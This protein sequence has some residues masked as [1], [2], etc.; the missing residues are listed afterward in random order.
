MIAKMYE[1]VTATQQQSQANAKVIANME[2]QIGQMAENQQKRDDGKLPSTTEV[3][4]THG[5]RAG[6]EHV[7]TVESGWRKFTL[8]D[9]FEVGEMEPEERE[10]VLGKLETEESKDKESPVE[11]GTQLEKK[12]REEEQSAVAGIKQKK[13]DKKGKRKQEA[14]K[15]MGPLINQPRWDELKDAPEDTRILQEMCE[16]NGQS[17]APTPNTVRLTVKASEALL[18]TLPKKEKDPGSPLITTTI[19]DVVIRNTLLDLGASVNI[20]PGY[21]YDKYKNEEIE[22]AKVVLQLADQSTKVSRGRLTNV[23]VKV[24]DFFYPV[25][26]LVMEY[27]SLDDAPALI[28]GRPFLATAGAVIDCKTGDVDISFGTRKRRL[29]MF[30]NPLSLPSEDDVNQLDRS[31]LMEPRVKSKKKIWT[32]TG[33]GGKEEILKETRNHPLATIEKE[34]LL[35]MIEMLELRHQQYEKESREREANVFKLLKSQQQWISGV[36]DRMT[37]LTSLMTRMA[38]NFVPGFQQMASRVQQ[39]E[40]E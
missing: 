35:E 12:V 23:I 8:E 4:P 27:E 16:R 10:K 33:E 1:M 13:K 29:N 18:G 37:Q 40:E 5:Q 21:L 14:P 30:G 6:K 28:L 26:F 15:S 32:R 20:L 11:E 19:G 36:S 3:N 24:G 39:Q 25:D 17:K 38:N 9:L 2:R 22:P 31:V 34:Q 7:S